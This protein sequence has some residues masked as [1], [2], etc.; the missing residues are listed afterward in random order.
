MKIVPTR[1]GES[2]AERDPKFGLCLLRY[3]VLRDV[4]AHW[5]NEV[6]KWKV[7]GRRSKGKF[8]ANL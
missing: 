8:S 4:E 6:E 2:L 7:G 5:A 1:A 3:S